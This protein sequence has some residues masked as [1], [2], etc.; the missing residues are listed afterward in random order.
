S[1]EVFGALDAITPGI[2]G[3]PARAPHPPAG[4]PG[5]GPS[6][7]FSRSNLSVAW[8]ESFASLLELAG[9]C[10]VPG[11]GAG[12]TGGCHTGGTGLVRGEVDY[13]PAP[14]DPPAA[15]SAL[16]CCSQPRGEVALD[17]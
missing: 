3:A 4:A 9:A 6:I 7:A 10:G 17:L 16:I 12:P 5:T 14:L 1:S 8:D 15:G 11:R 13:R 2:A